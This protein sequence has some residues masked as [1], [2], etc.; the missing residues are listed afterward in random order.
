[1][2][3]SDL[4]RPVHELNAHTRVSTPLPGILGDYASD[5]KTGGYFEKLLYISILSFIVGPWFNKQNALRD[6][7]LLMMIS[8][9]S[10]IP[11]HVYTSKEF[12][13]AN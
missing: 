4:N 12:Y 2:F 11:I 7:F 9:R 13:G 8:T 1:M 5:R 10:L 6:Y 3:R